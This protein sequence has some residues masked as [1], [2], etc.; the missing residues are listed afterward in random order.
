MNDGATSEVE[1][2]KV[3]QPAT[4]TPDPVRQRIVHE[5]GP[6]DAEQ[7]ERLEALALG[8]GAGDERWCDDG[9]HHLE[10]HECEMRDR[11]RVVGVWLDADV[12]QAN[13]AQ[14]PNDPPDVRAECQTVAPE[15]PLHAD[16]SEDEET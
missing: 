11:R 2:A 15:H 16:E 5:R 8:E 6:E 9:E 4:S 12:L 3:V 10:G 13:P 14:A 1:G 7:D